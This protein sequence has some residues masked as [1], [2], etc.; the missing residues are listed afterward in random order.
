MSLSRAVAQRLRLRIAP[1]TAC[2]P[3]GR[4]FSRTAV[5][6]HS[7]LRQGRWRWNSTET[8]RLDGSN[9]SSSSWL[10]KGLVLTLKLVLIWVPA[11]AAWTAVVSG[12]T[13]DLRTPEE[14]NQEEQEAQKLERFFDVE[15]LPEVEYAAEWG[16][17]EQALASIVDKL[18]RSRTVQESMELLP[19]DTAPG[20]SERSEEAEAVMEFSYIHPPPQASSLNTLDVEI[21]SEG[22]RPW[23][24]RLILAHTSGSLALVTMRFQHLQAAHGRSETWSCTKLRVELISSSPGALEEAICDLQGPLPHGVRYMRI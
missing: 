1:Q 20:P 21:A 22:Y 6:H 16:A 3:H 4:S 9:I 8:P 23:N 18:T 5:A 15:H 19:V 2:L 11:L 10:R 14:I 13:L 7:L 12:V 24:P 17:K